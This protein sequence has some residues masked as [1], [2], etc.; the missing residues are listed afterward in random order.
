MGVREK[1]VWYFHGLE[2]MYTT[3]LTENKGLSDLFLGLG[4][5]LP[6]SINHFDWRVT[7]G[8]SLPLAKYKPEEPTHSASTFIDSTSIIHQVR[9]HYN[10]KMGSGTMIYH[11]GTGLQYS[12]DNFAITGLAN[13]S[14]CL[15][16]ASTYYWESRLYEN[17]FSYQQVPL[18]TKPGNT[19]SYALIFDYQALDW[20][21]IFGRFSGVMYSG[22]WDEEEDIRIGHLEGNI[23]TIGIG[24]EIQVARRLRLFQSMDLPIA[25][26]N[27]LAPLILYTGASFNFLTR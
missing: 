15:K 19:L 9:Y 7:A 2:T 4:V 18:K 17:E 3:Q 11:F 21:D 22:G 16:E 10:N 27:Q 14:L 20:F 24:Y 6:F 5:R 8:V 13:Y 26:K 1:Q 23:M 25:G 12:T